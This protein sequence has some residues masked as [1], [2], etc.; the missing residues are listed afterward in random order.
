MIKHKGLLF[1]GY[2]TEEGDWPW[3]AAI[4]HLNQFS[5]AYKCGG[6]LINSNTILTAAHCVYENGLRINAERVLVKL[7]KYTLSV[8]APDTRES[9]A[10][11][12]NVHQN[13][14]TMNLGH[15]IALIRLRNEITFN[16]HIQPG[17]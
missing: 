1:N 8:N 3:H 13:Y 10:Q 9:K 11:S 12:I 15:D 16:E 4:Y 6:T 2:T 5:Q 17:M 14:S 7:G